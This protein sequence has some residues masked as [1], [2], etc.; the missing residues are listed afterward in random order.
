MLDDTENVVVEDTATPTIQ[1]SAPLEDVTSSPEAE[2]APQGDQPQDQAPGQSEFDHLKVLDGLQLDPK[3]KEALKNGYLRQADYTKKTQDLA[4]IRSVVTEYQKARPMMEFLG[5]NPDLFN[6]VYQ[7]MQGQDQPNGQDPQIPDD[8]RAYADWVKAE[9]I[10]EIQSM[11][12]QDADF[13]AA[14]KSDPRLDSD[15]E[16]GEMVARMVVN[17]PDF[18]SKSISA[19]EATK[20][21]VERFDKYMSTQITK[22]KTTLS[23]KA[24]MKR[25]G[26]TLRSSPGTVASGKKPMSIMEAAQQAEEELG[27]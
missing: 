2:S 12:A 10:K 11:Q 19:A 4:K 8:P 27:S 17:D 5:K 3:I 6:Q 20:R 1:S 26:S 24:K 25:V 15:P 22:A 18:K 9:T 21:A 14:A 23:E 13:Q 7:K 16:F